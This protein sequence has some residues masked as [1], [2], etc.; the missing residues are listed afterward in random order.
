MRVTRARRQQGDVKIFEYGSWNFSS[1][2]F[3]FIVYNLK[4]RKSNLKNKYLESAQAYWMW[5]LRWKYLPNRTRKQQLK[6]NKDPFFFFI[7][8]LVNFKLRL[9]EFTDAHIGHVYNTSKTHIIWEQMY[10]F[11]TFPLLCHSSSLERGWV[12]VNFIVLFNSFSV[13]FISCDRLNK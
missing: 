7:S 5:I 3:L 11:S 4:M 1:Q 10:P 9:D 8:D 13:C 6:W 2:F 12:Y